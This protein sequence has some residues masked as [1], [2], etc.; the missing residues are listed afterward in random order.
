MMISENVAVSV[1]GR[2]I[3]STKTRTP[4]SLRRDRPAGDGKHVT[5]PRTRVEP[6]QQD[7]SRKGLG[8]PRCTRGLNS[9]DSLSISVPIT[10]Q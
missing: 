2:R 6:R 5:G 7:A 10:S 8:S 4:P 3:E 1:R 9:G